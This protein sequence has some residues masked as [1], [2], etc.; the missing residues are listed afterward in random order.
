M[1]G[2]QP[3]PLKTHANWWW[4]RFYSYH[5]VLVN[6]SLAVMSIW[7][8][9]IAVPFTRLADT[10]SGLRHE[11]GNHTL[12]QNYQS[13]ATEFWSGIDRD[14][15]PPYSLYM[16]PRLQ[17][18]GTCFTYPWTDTGIVRPLLQDNLKGHISK[19]LLHPQRK[20]KVQLDLELPCLDSH[21]R[22]KD[23][24]EIP[25]VN[26][27][28]RRLFAV[29]QNATRSPYEHINSKPPEIIETA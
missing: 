9:Q 18:L 22:V 13:C 6:T 21:K 4:L 12:F 8:M 10:C 17:S 11:H 19:P 2:W 23:A 20:I 14:N 27:C 29:C 26:V 28:S 16:L 3:L 5:S 1:G 15:V 24:K 25:V 7:I